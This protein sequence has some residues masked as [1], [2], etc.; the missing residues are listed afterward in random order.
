MGK[1]Q[2]VVQRN[3]LPVN[4][5]GKYAYYYFVLDLKDESLMN[6]AKIKEEVVE[7]RTQFLSSKCMP[8]RKIIMPKSINH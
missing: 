5:M 7:V 1:P 2:L 6:N 4:E 3:S 8:F